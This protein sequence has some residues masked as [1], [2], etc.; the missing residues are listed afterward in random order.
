MP[1][2]SVVRSY[3]GGSDGGKQAS[4]LHRCLVPELETGD[5]QRCGGSRERELQCL[6][7][8]PRPTRNKEGSGMF[9]SW[10]TYQISIPTFSR[11]FSCRASSR[12]LISS[13]VA[14]GPFLT[15]GHNPCTW[16]L[17]LR[18]FV[19]TKKEFPCGEKERSSMQSL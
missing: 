15:S 10:K 6:L 3:A 13:L 2:T 17:V 11:P 5:R 4:R 14:L 8:L 19:I 1:K 7:T 9:W 16:P 12:T 18:K